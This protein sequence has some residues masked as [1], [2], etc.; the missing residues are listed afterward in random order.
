[1]TPFPN[2]K[3]WMHRM[4]EIPAVERCCALKDALAKSYDIANAE[5]EGPDG[6]IHWRDSRLEWPLR[7]GFADFVLRE[8][9]AGKMMFP[10]DA[11]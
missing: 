10:P 1:M 5:L 8:F 4:R 3:K 2:L 6:K 9:N 11:A 7:R